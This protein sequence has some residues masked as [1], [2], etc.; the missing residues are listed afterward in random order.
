MPEISS[1]SE[2]VIS[3]AKL[4]GARYIEEGNARQIDLRWTIP[5]SNGMDLDFYELKYCIVS[6]PG[7]NVNIHVKH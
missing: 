5:P 4:Q 3:N 2:P 6:I 7:G 1:P